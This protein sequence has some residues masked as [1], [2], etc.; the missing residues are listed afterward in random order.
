MKKMTKWLS[1]L[2]AGLMLSAALLACN[3][4]SS[5][6]DDEDEDDEDEEQSESFD[7]YKNLS[8]QELADAL[9]ECPSYKITATLHAYEYGEQVGERNETIQKQND[10]VKV[11]TVK[12]PAHS[13]PTTQTAYYDLERFVSYYSNENGGW[14][15]Y[16]SNGELK[17]IAIFEKSF[18]AEL[19]INP[20]VYGEYDSETKSYPML[21]E[22]MVEILNGGDQMSAS[23]SMSPS[24]TTYTFELVAEQD[25]FRQTFT[26][27][28]EFK[29]VQV[30]LPAELAP[31]TDENQPDV[32]PTPDT[33]QRPVDT[34]K[35]PEENPPEEAP[36]PSYCPFAFG[37]SSLEWMDTFSI[38]LLHTYDNGYF[39]SI[40]VEKSDHI[41]NLSYESTEQTYYVYA[42]LKNQLIYTQTQWNGEIYWVC[43]PTD[44]YLTWDYLLEQ[45]MVAYFDPLAHD[46]SY[47]WTYDFSDGTYSWY[48]EDSALEDLSNSMGSKIEAVSLWGDYPYDLSERN[49]WGKYCYGI[50]QASVY[51]T[52]EIDYSDYTVSIPSN[53]ISKNEFDQMIEDATAFDETPY[54]NL[55][56]G[57]LY[58]ALLNSEEL[59]FLLRDGDYQTE[60]RKS[61]DILELSMY[62]P[63]LGDWTY[64]YVD[65]SAGTMYQMMNPG[66]YVE[67]AFIHTWEESLYSFGIERHSYFFDDECY[68]PFGASDSYLEMDPD[69]VSFEFRF[70]GMTREGATYDYEE[71]TENQ[72]YTQLILRFEDQNITLPF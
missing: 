52:L 34:N 49:E 40:Y 44:T 69:V 43:E 13:D 41:V 6:S 46:L 33:T 35:V 20:E 57:E 22:K 60:I 50:S 26:I 12:K 64:C 55:N 24:G 56:P 2:L 54:L 28:I 59:Y 65:L 67:F 58:D 47:Y 37:V 71:F 17:L 48:F 36:I 72:E 38:S 10:W 4:S 9:K 14:D 18:P 1:L 23:G 16:V 8:P 29:S 45:T 62:D 53:T 15:H 11:E 30:K 68:L 19:L 7:E 51:S 3:D 5:W 61:G 32:K 63:E 66:H 70:A 31:E 39:E 21:P 25:P 27:V 42:D